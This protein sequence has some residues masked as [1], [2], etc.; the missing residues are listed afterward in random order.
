MAGLSSNPK[1]GDGLCAAVRYL[2]D[3]FSSSIPNSINIITI[4]R[5]A[6]QRFPMAFKHV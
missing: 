6:G 5:L 3:L 2:R 1:G 4:D